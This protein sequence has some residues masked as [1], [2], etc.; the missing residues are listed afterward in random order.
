MEELKGNRAE[1]RGKKLNDDC[2]M[3]NTTKNELGEHDNRVFCY[4]LNDA[5]TEELI[6]ECRHCKANVV[7][8]ELHDRG[9][10]WNGY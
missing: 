1:L 4:G 6:D 9:A 7:N 10:L 5:S 2:Y 3:A 8:I